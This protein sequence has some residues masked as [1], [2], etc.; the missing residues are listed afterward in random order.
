MPKDLDSEHSAL[1]ALYMMIAVVAFSALPVLFKLGGAEE[2]PFLFT[3]IR[4]GSI[5]IALSAVLL[6]VIRKLRIKPEVISDITEDIKVHCKTRL[7]LVSVVGTFDFVLFAL[8]LAFVDVSIAATLYETWP[9]FLMPIM[10]FLFKGT[11]RYRA[12]SAG[13]WIFV[14]L[15]LV[16]V[17][18]VILSHNDTPQ[19]LLEIGA[20]FAD[21]RTLIGVIIVLT[22]AIFA[23]A[24]VACTLKLGI[25]L[26]ERH[27]RKEGRKAAEIVFATIMTS[28]CLVIVGGASFVVGL[29]V[30][31]TFSLHQ[32]FYAVLT[33]FLVGS[34]GIVALRAANLTT[35]NLGVNA[36]SYATPLVA[37]IWLW[38]FSILGVSHI[39]YLII[40]ALGIV[41]SNLLI[42]ARADKRVAYS[43]LVMSLWVFGTVLYFTDGSA[44]EVPL[45]LPVTIFILVLAFRVDRLARRTSQ[46]EVW[47]FEAFSKLEFLTSKKQLDGDALRQLLEIDE[48][49][50][51]KGL[52]TAYIKL[53][54]YLAKPLKDTGMDKSAADDIK[55]I[56]HLVNNLAHSRQQGANFGELVAIALAG[57]LIVLGLLFFNGNGG[58]YGEIVSLSLSSVVVFLFVNILDLQNDRRDQILERKAGHYVVKFDD[59]TSRKGQQWIS[60]VTSAVI[61]V[62]F[63]V[64]FART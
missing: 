41:A 37:L 16:G 10:S 62:V 54:G 28:I 35:E 42:N 63:A 12:I 31:E 40:G 26:A 9:L 19:P 8:G 13:T 21:P 23:A 25:S 34:I 32:L 36:L 58:L 24:R 17:A 22:A 57:G 59:D 4:Q 29:I 14:V 7:M 39:D 27:S 20:D 46:E 50:S 48:H 60:V 3:G 18:L 43:A 38:M 5:V 2:S 33:G 61:V 47:M 56:R 44:T 64:L 45:E 15:S 30:S 49:K 1:P 6:L 52:S 55:D 51:P 53:A 11:K